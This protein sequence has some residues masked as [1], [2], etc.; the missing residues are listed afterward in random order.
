MTTIELINDLAQRGIELAADGKRLLYRPRQAV[1]ESLRATLANRKHEI[2]E[3]LRG[4]EQSDSDSARPSHPGTGAS[5]PADASPF[6]VPNGWDR[7]A[8]I[9]RLRYLASVCINPRRK[10]EL[11]QW[12]EGLET[13]PRKEINRWP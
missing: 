3:L 6:E 10:L 7:P 5:S 13:Q 11:E 1:D 12:A 2:L 9:D 4:H 8:W